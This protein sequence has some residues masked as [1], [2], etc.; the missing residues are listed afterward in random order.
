MKIVSKFR[1]IGFA[2]AIGLFTFACNQETQ[3]ETNAEVDEAQ[4]ELSEENA[5]ANAELNE[6]GAEANQEYDEFSGWV[7][8]NTEKAETVTAD[9][10][11]EMRAEYNRKEAEFEAES[12]TWDEETRREWEET[13]AE[14][15]EFENKVQK[16]LGK[17]DDID[18][19]VDINRD[20]N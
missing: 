11:R 9:E 1:T 14:W 6:A 20:N 15:N 2:L 5:E 8:T 3:N 17:I 10:Y 18:V 4:T 12:S 13:K 19:D 16:R 7:K